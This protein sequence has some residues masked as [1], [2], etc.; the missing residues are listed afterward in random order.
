VR[1]CDLVAAVG[2]TVDV[3]IVGGGPAGLQAA[4]VL[5]RA[6]RTVAVIDAGQP[7]NRNARAVH[8]LCG[9]EGIAPG[10]LLAQSRQDVARYGVEIIPGEVVDAH[11]DDL[12]WVVRPD[13]GEALRTRAIV[14]ATGVVEDLPAVAG[15]ADLWG[16][17]V[18]SCPYCHGW[19]ARDKA[20]AVLGTGP[21]AWR[22][23]LLLRRFTE[24]LVLV[25]GEPAGL[26]DRQLDHVERA[27]IVV[28]EQPVARV[29]SQG[30]H[31]AGIEFAD[32]T[33]LAR[34]VVFAATTR[35]QPS[36][37]AA[38]LGCVIEAEGPTSPGIRTDPT[39][40][41]SVPGVWAVGSAGDP[42]LTVAG[43]AG[44]ATGVAIALNDSF[45]DDDLARNGMS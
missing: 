12:G 17:D 41:T 32:G 29:R 15:L 42:R 43:S 31:L 1:R 38:K 44:Q 19:E 37:L 3:V 26:D 11:R 27:G 6:L 8:N 4:L 33:V 20:V 23:L 36:G 35:R 34:D 18:V 25:A 28:R 9:Q 2:R 5:G 24:D 16:G 13:A 10:R 7:R 22:Q 21:R 14:L 39:G 40:R 30:G 45:I